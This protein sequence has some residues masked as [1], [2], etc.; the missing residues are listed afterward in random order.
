MH[1]IRIESYVITMPDREDIV[2]GF[3]LYPAGMKAKLANDV[4]WRNDAISGL[5]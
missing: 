2:R 1:D 4:R 5:I 3:K